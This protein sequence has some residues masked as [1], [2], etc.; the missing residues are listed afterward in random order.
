[1]RIFILTALCLLASTAQAAM[2]WTFQNATLSDGQT[3]SGSFD[4]DA[5][6]QVFSHIAIFN[7]GNTLYAAT[8]YVATNG[9][10][11]T[12]KCGF[13]D[14]TP[15]I[16]DNYLSIWF[17]DNDTYLLPALGGNFQLSDK[18]FSTFFFCQ[19]ASCNSGHA[20]PEQVVTFTGGSLT[21]VPVPA[22]LWLM[23]SALLGLIASARA[24]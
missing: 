20:A 8:H 12:L 13:T 14:G 2:T 18:H 16:G 5:N 23:G 17:W 4:Y 1:M 6:T 9:A 11:S 19:N 15:S 21:S 24:R 22:A 10:C 3:L 7:S